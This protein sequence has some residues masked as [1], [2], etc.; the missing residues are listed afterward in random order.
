MYNQPDANERW[1][2]R[3][4]HRTYWTSSI[5]TVVREYV[6]ADSGWIVLLGG[7]SEMAIPYAHIKFIRR[8]AKQT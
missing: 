2:V 4:K 5:V 7:V 8:I 6:G 1:H 3:I